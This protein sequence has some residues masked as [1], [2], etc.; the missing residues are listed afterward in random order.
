MLVILLTH[1]ER[2]ASWW[3][4][5]VIIMCAREPQVSDSQKGIH[6]WHYNAKTVTKKAIEL[7]FAKYMKDAYK[8][9]F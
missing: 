4:S 3:N 6:V 8:I 7:V 5:G 1:K 9:V 2:C